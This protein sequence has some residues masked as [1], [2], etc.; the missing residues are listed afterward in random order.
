MTGRIEGQPEEKKARGE[1]GRR[2]AS[3]E[4]PNVFILPVIFVLFFV[5]FSYFVSFKPHKPPYKVTL[6]SPLYRGQN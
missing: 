1:E 6:S 5:S 2:R 4:Q 3:H